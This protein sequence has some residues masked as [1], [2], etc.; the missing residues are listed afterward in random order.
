MHEFNAAN[1]GQKALREF[2]EA[3]RKQMV[4]ADAAGITAA[5][6]S[7]LPDVDKAALASDSDIAQYMVDS[8]ADGLA[9]NTDGWIDDD[10]AFIAPWGFD[11]AD[12]KVPVIVCQGT[13]DKMV[14]FAHGEWLAKHIPAAFV[15]AHLHQGEGHLSAVDKYLDGMLDELLSYK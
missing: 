5:M 12:I 4:G 10:M 11:V 6:D 14:P 8:F 13:D 9:C 1:K 7:L 15:K 2:T 3:A